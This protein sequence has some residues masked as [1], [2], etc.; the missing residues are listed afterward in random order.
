MKRIFFSTIVLSIIIIKLGFSQ[1]PVYVLGGAENPN[2]LLVLKLNTVTCDY[3]TISHFNWQNCDLLYN[4]RGNT[5][6]CEY[7]ITDLQCPNDTGILFMG[8]NQ[9]T[10]FIYH[11]TSPPLL[12]YFPVEA[13]YNPNDN[14]LYTLSVNNVIHKTE[15]YKHDLSTNQTNLFVTLPLE[16]GWIPNEG[17]WDLCTIDVDSNYMYCTA[18]LEKLL[19]INLSNGHVDSIDIFHYSPQDSIYYLSGLSFDKDRR[20]ILGNH[21]DMYGNGYLVAVNTVT[22]EKTVLGNTLTCCALSSAYNDE[23]DIY[24]IYGGDNKYYFYNSLNGTFIDSCTTDS[25]NIITCFTPICSNTVNIAENIEHQSIKVY[26]TIV[27]DRLFIDS[28]KNNK[29]I[30]YIIYDNLGRI[31]VSNKIEKPLTKQIEIKLPQLALGSYYVSDRQSASF[32]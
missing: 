22:Y 7:F 32:L 18:Q 24:T 16:Y 30:Y 23:N 13:K 27:N 28:K 31:V 17:K 6:S 19:K 1:S 29:E 26:P 11:Y 2:R 25:E 8:L 14:S 15:I 20:I 12:Q 21:T 5:A 10:S 3:D 4:L 9:D